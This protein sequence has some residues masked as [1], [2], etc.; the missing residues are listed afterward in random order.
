MSTPKFSQLL[1]LICANSNHKKDYKTRNSGNGFQST[2]N[3]LEIRKILQLKKHQLKLN[4][5]LKQ[6]E[7]SFQQKNRKSINKAWNCSKDST[8]NI[9]SH[10]NQ[11]F[12]PI[13]HH[14]NTMQDSI[15]ICLPIMFKT[16]NRKFKE[17]PLQE[18][19]DKSK[20]YSL[21]TRKD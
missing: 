20:E 13:F 14:N 15:N 1:F 17:S 7:D 10:K 8:F 18:C 11:W 4:N 9:P 5:K 16:D 21:M 12:N 6:S 3:P 19:R 2:K